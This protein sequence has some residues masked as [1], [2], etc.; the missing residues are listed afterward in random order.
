MFQ[1]LHDHAV[2]RVEHG[3]GLGKSGLVWYTT[4]KYIGQPGQWA[5]LRARVE[6]VG[7]G[8]KI[9]RGERFGE[10]MPVDLRVGDIV[11]I[12]RFA[13]LDLEDFEDLRL[14]RQNEALMIEET[15]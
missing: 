10:R 3:E 7:P 1:P 8:R 14:I 9:K 4:R 12:G 11:W 15:P 2:V 5:I 13:G 6:A